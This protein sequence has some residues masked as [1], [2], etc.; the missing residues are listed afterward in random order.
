L[1][2]RRHPTFEPAL[3]TP[4]FSYLRRHLTPESGVAL[5]IKQMAE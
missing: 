1:G 4:A 5:E 2:Y 3:A